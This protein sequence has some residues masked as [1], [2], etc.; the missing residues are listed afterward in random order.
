MDKKKNALKNFIMYSLVSYLGVIIGFFSLPITT[1]I[2]N[3]IQFGKFSL[4]M[5][6]VN[7]SSIFIFSGFDY[8]YQ[9]YYHE[10]L[11]NQK[12]LL[13]KKCIYISFFIYLIGI[14]IALICGNYILKILNLDT[15]IELIF[16][17]IIIFFTIVNRYLGITLVMQERMVTYS[18]IQIIGQSLNIILIFLFYTQ[19]SPTFLILI[20]ST[21]IMLSIISLIYF[22]LIKK[23]LVVN[24]IKDGIKTLAIS[25]KDLINYSIPMLFTTGLNWIFQSIDKIGINRYSTL[26]ELGYYSAAFKIASILIVIE[27]SFISFWNSTSYKVYVK[28][29]NEKVFFEKIANYVTFFVIFL[30]LGVLL[31]KPVIIFLLGENYIKSM[32]I[33]PYLLLIPIMQGISEITGVGINFSKKTKYNTI[34]SLIIAI[35]NVIG[36][37]LLIPKMGA[38]G[39]GISTAICYLL[40]FILKT[41]WSVKFIR[42]SFSYIK[43][44]LGLVLLIFNIIYSSL[45]VF[46]VRNVV[47]IFVSLLILLLIFKNDCFEI[48]KELQKLIRKE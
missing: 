17:F 19:L 26:K 9:R 30:G 18:V 33:M 31:C 35:I 41:Y 12:S 42:Y 6:F 14:T 21:M 36:N 39:A 1:R 16:V 10:V 37:I 48:K 20:Y 13:L 34:I 8:G 7:V 3:P 28:K 29:P 47:I 32:E 40:Y 45:Y 5:L 23:T 46:D 38:K 22:I 15:Y 27:V 4:I 11:D 44:F 43:I 24:K 25:N 2:L